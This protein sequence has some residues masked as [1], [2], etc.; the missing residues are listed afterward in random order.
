MN[1]GT[2]TRALRVEPDVGI[3]FNISWKRKSMLVT[4]QQ[5]L[6]DSVTVIVSLGTELADVNNNRLGQPFQLAFSTGTSIDSAGV[7]IATVSF[8]SVRGED[9]MTVGLFRESALDQPAVYMSESDTSGIV[10]FRY[11]TP[12]SYRAFIFD[13]RNRNWIIDSGERL[14][15]AGENVQVSTDSIRTAATIA[16]TE[17]DTVRP[18]ILGVGL[19]SDRRLRIRFSEEVQ[20]SEKS[21]ISLKADNGLFTTGWLYTDPSD[22][23]IAYARSNE[24]LLPNLAFTV[25]VENVADRQGN[26]VA[27]F[28]QSFQGSAQ[29]DTTQMRIIR[30]PGNGIVTPSDS[31]L[32]VYS[33]ILEGSAVLDSLTL[34]DGDRSVKPWTDIVM[35][36][37]RARVYRSGG[38]R[39]GQQYQLRAWNPSEQRFLLY[40]FRVEDPSTFG[41]IEIQFLNE[42]TDDQK[43]A[44]LLIEGE[45]VYRRS[46]NGTSLIIESVPPGDYSLRVWVDGNEN[47]RWDPPG[48]INRGELVHLQRVVPVTS[49]LTSTISIE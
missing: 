12:G 42:W 14:F 8:D 40:S 29:P 34:I 11:A 45:T 49:R 44:E 35:T 36:A 23:T 20:L 31:L 33:D 22:A 32:I 30:I 19:L 1:R 38:W 3:P 47:G 37:N 17:L 21:G 15:P 24:S 26:Q 6:P 18:T 16:Y 2:A 25:S 10:R 5:S 41:N 46:S 39:V 28:E 7:D 9:G 48:L 13:D 4:F 43:I 27:P